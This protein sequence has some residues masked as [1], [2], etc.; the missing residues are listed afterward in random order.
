M[1]AQPSGL[2]PNGHLP[3]FRRIGPLMTHQSPQGLRH[4]GV[5]RALDQAA[6]AQAP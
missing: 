3:P 6:R 2:A 1:E 4:L 5:G